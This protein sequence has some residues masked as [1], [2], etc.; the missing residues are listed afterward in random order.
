MRDDDGNPLIRR[1]G[2]EDN[3]L[4][5]KMRDSVKKPVGGLKTE[6]ENNNEHNNVVKRNKQVELMSSENKDCNHKIKKPEKIDCNHDH[7]QTKEDDCKQD[8]NQEEWKS[9]KSTCNEKEVKSTN[10]NIYEILLEEDDENTHNDSDENEEITTTTNE[11]IEVLDDNIDNEVET[12]DTNHNEK[13]Q[14]NNVNSKIRSERWKEVNLGESYVSSKAHHNL[15][16]AVPGQLHLGTIL[17]QG[18]KSG[19]MVDKHGNRFDL[20]RV[21]RQLRFNGR[22]YDINGTFEEVEFV[23]DTACAVNILKLE[24]ASKWDVEKNKTTTVSGYAGGECESLNGANNLKVSLKLS[25]KTTT[26][27]LEDDVISWA[28]V[29]EIIALTESGDYDAQLSKESI[30]DA[31]VKMKQIEEDKDLQD[32]IDKISKEEEVITK[33]KSAKAIIDIMNHE[34]IKKESSKGMKPLSEAIGIQRRLDKMKEYHQKFPHLSPASLNKMVQ[35]GQIKDGIEIIE[36]N[37]TDYNHLKSKATKSRVHRKKNKKKQPDPGLGRRAPFFVTMADLIDLSN[38]APNNRWGY[39]Y[40]LTMTCKEYGVVKVYPLRSKADVAPAWIQFQQWLK[41]IAPYVEAK[42]GM[43]PMVVIFASDRGSEFMTTKGTTR[44]ELDEILH[45]CGVARWT[46]ST[47]DSN[48]LGQVERFNR[49]LMENINEMLMK[50]NAGV[51]YVFD[52]ATFFEQHFNCTPTSSNKVGKGVAPFTTLGIPF[53]HEKFVEFF[54]PA[55]VKLP[56]HEKVKIGPKAELGYIIGYGTAMMLGGDTDGYKV[57]M[58]RT[59]EV[60]ATAHVTPINEKELADVKREEKDATGNIFEDKPVIGPKEEKMPMQLSEDQVQQQVLESKKNAAATNITEPKISRKK[61]I[62]SGVTGQT[63]NEMESPS[64]VLTRNDVMTKSQAKDVLR[65]AESRKDIMNYVPA[66]KCGKKKDSLTRYKKYCNCKSLEIYHK[67]CKKGDDSARKP[68]L[69][70]DIQKGLL[71]FELNDDFMRRKENEDFKYVNALFNTSLNHEITNED[72]EAKITITDCRDNQ[73]IDNKEQSIFIN[74]VEQMW[75]DET[76]KETLKLSKEIYGKDEIELHVVC[77]IFKRAEVWVDGRKQPYTIKEAMTLKEWPEWKAAIIKEIK[78]LI[79]IGLWEEIPLSE[80]PDGQ[81]VLPGRMVLTIKSI[82]GKFDKCKARYVSRGDLSH[83]GQHYWDSSSHQMKSKSLRIYMALSAEE[84]GRTG[85]RCSIPHSLDI[86]QAYLLAKRTKDQSSIFMQLPEQTFGL[87]RD[88][89][90][91][92]VAKM[93]RHL[94]G[95][96]DGGRAFE[97]EMVKFMESIGA[98][99]TVSDRMVFKWKW[100]GMTLKALVHVDDIIYNGSDDKILEEFYKRSVKYFGECTGGKIAEFILGIKVEWD[101]ENATVKLSQ[102][103]HVEKFLEEFGF[104]IS[105]TKIKKTP[106]PVGHEFVENSGRRILPSEW[107]YF[108]WCGFAN[109]LVTNTRT[110][111]ANGVNMLGRYSQNPG[112][113]HVAVQKHL[114]RYLAGTRND[115]ITYHGKKSTLMTPYDHRNKLVVYVDSNHQAGHDT[116]CVVVM[117][118]GGVVINRV[119]KQRVV[120]TS[121]AHSEMIALAAGVKEVMWASDYMKEMGF[122]QGSVRLMGDNQS[123][124]LQATGDYKSSKSDHYRKVQFYVEDNLRQGL[125]WIDK[126]KTE[127]NIADIGTKQV[128]PVEQFNKLKNIMMGVTPSLVETELVSKILSGEYDN[129]G[130]EQYINVIRQLHDSNVEMATA[131]KNDQSQRK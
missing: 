42:L 40:L 126:V 120:S 93:L 26:F 23:H 10:E 14:I 35:D 88:K 50:K 123:A 28:N 75:D 9:P 41:I 53:E 115:G 22:I 38:I 104:E 116:M 62:G 52:A 127:M 27:R 46:P 109:W 95:E 18:E 113:D 16:A 69:V 59:G 2:E 65:L 54:Q 12:N 100:N 99:A 102:G 8:C 34:E 111:I 66:S 61:H 125:I 3:V 36:E 29:V 81:Q 87:C 24:N 129:L 17:N 106:T 83:R 128:K 77:A 124:N 74:N 31:D 98:V 7:N 112:E 67:L 110:D 84:Y 118:N 5:R 70:N 6:I 21:G 49:T 25:D 121:T 103:A 94:Y 108:K 131:L 107:D 63:R 51:D 1:V 114:L 43:T 89:Y 96:V 92:Y 19:Y 91:G 119:L 55:L 80:V 117:L 60:Y 13:E 58:A 86:K 45:A 71:T 101:Y 57:V 33:V 73:P 37:I 11:N 30:A 4:R 105:T 97:R 78:G 90:S 130:T 76:M 39:K 32:F 15:F 68:D 48:K 85:K 64:E 122:E 20:R 72:G 44:G 79:D 82:D 56:S 47:G